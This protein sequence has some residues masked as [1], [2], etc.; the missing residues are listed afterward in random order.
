GKR[1]KPKA[2]RDIPAAAFEEDVEEPL[3][4]A[5]RTVK[6]KTPKAAAKPAPNPAPVPPPPEG[7]LI[8]P[9]ELLNEPSAD[10]ADV[11]IA[12]IDEMGQRLIQTLETFRV[13]GRIAD[14]TVGPVVT[15][16]E[17]EPGPGVKVGRISG[18]AD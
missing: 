4:P 14:R 1:E 3:R 16:F 7:S 11:G 8:P 13:G 5:E 18:L 15:R 6:P 10:T 9:I 12:Q 17:I 2:K